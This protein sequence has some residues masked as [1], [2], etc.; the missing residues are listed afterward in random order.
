MGKHTFIWAKTQSWSQRH[1]I[2]SA[3]LVELSHSLCDKYW[4]TTSS[5]STGVRHCGGKH[6]QQPAKRRGARLLLYNALTHMCSQE[7]TASGKKCKVYLS[8][9]C[10]FFLFFLIEITVIPRFNQSLQWELAAW[11][12]RIV[13]L[14]LLWYLM[15]PFHSSSLEP[16]IYETYSSSL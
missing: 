13:L 14:W 15:S 11:S 8:L 7:N 5:R 12:P 2:P 4:C 16:P 6:A 10:L 9:N 1:V 3:L